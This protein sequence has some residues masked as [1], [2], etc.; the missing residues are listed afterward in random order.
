MVNALVIR[1]NTQLEKT[2]RALRAAQYVRMS[3]DYQRYSIESQAAVIA[4]YAQTRNLSIV[5]TYRDEGE[6]GLNLKNRAGLLQLLDDVE[7]D[8]ADFGHILIYDVS[9]WG[10]FQDIDESAYYEFICKQAGIKVAYCAEQFENDDS[11]V[12]SIVKNI[13]RVMAAEYSRELSVKVHAGA[14]RFAG[15]G[16]KSGGPTPY[17]LERVLV[18]EKRQPKGILKKGDRK[19]IQT[20][21]VRLQPGGVKEVTIVK[22]IFRRFLDVKSET[23]L[24]RELNRHGIPPC[25]GER[26]TGPK[27]TRILKNENYIG[28]IV[29]NRQSSKLRTNR[30]NNSPDK[31]IRTKGC[32]E[33]IVALD[34]FLAAKKIITER[35]VD[36]LTE[37]EMLARLR[38]TLMKEGRLTPK[39]ISKTVDL[40]SH[41]VYRAHFG[42]M[43]NAY[44]LVG[45]VP[46]R[47]FEYWESRHIWLD[48]LSQ[49]QSQVA[50]RIEK[51]VA[52]VVPNE[53]A[54]G[55]RVNGVN[56]YF[57]IAQMEHPGRDHY[58][59]RWF[60]QRRNLP[61][62][63]IVAIRLA[64][65]SK[66]LRDYL[67][68]PTIRTD[69]NTIRFSE[70]R[71]TRLGIA[72]FQ[73]PEALARSL[74][75]RV[76][77]LDHVAPAKPA[78]Q[79]RRKKPI[80]PKTKN[81][82]ARR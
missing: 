35:R 18:D 60:I 81:G 9:R 58:A 61:D 19:Y 17:A 29:Y 52:R 7:S 12:S 44:R 13:K 66:T 5:R 68:V 20:D 36:G 45:Y 53:L 8:R 80:R 21:H 71:R 69:R 28:N 10:R 55:L 11:M 67:L 31:W 27:I 43:R 32:I 46:K 73:T 47:N 24:A 3:T 1:R 22:W 79:N 39:I 62:G 54:D 59:P 65:R 14:C 64:D 50:A 34:D 72:S 6:S 25:C 37:G 76:T 42:T 74:I 57:R 26:W 77:K 38:R 51:E 40:P 16:F 82:R 48:R 75:R 70:K 4:A 78:L 33:P 23:A 49:F 2:Q 56:I 63:W 41:H 15:M 30:V